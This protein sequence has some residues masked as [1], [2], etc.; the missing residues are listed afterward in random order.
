MRAAPQAQR[1]LLD[2]QAV[3]TAIAQLEHRRRS[4]PE[5]AR[6]AQG[7]RTRAELGEAIVAARTVVSDLEL[8]LEKAESDLVPVKE[9]RVRDQRRL[10]DGVVTDGKQLTALID[11]IEHLK[12]RISDLEDIQLEVMEKLE[13]ATAEHT[14]LVEQ[15][16]GLETSLR[17]LIGSRDEQ[18]AAIDAELASRRAA[19]DELAAG[20]P[21]D[22]V[23]LYRRIADRSGGVGVGAL[24]GRRCG[25]CQLEATPTALASYQSAAPDE[26]VRCEECDRIL[27]RGAEG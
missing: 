17:A 3:D 25:G 8:D 19:R 1:G 15:R 9:R 13:A 12:R 16:T 22:L 5:L 26:V 10:D 2:L 27:V 18:V 7:Q 21:E 23:A 14:G 24:K 4:L 6:I 11:E 20:L